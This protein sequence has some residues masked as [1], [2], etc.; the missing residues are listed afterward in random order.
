MLTLGKPPSNANSAGTSCDR[1]IANRALMDM[2]RC[3]H[4]LMKEND[5]DVKPEEES[6]AEDE[7]ARW[8]NNLG[9]PEGRIL[10]HK[11]KAPSSECELNL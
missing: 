1:F 2:D 11:Q 8:K 7:T 3:H 10:A 5:E 4:I 9:V 6:G